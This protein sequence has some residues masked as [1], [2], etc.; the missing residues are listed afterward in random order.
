MQK[1]GNSIS[2]TKLLWQKWFKEGPSCYSCFVGQVKRLGL[3]RALSFRGSAGSLSLVLTLSFSFAPCLASTLAVPVSHPCP[4]TWSFAHGVEG[5]PGRR[6]ACPSGRTLRNWSLLYYGWNPSGWC[7]CGPMQTG[8]VCWHG[9]GSGLR[10]LPSSIQS[11]TL[12]P[13]AGEIYSLW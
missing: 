8:W 4:M 2:P 10:G 3:V 13:G 5:I 7:P 12:Q 1:T 11:K 9:L 6:T